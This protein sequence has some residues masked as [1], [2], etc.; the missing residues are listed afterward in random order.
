MVVFHIKHGSQEGFLYEASVQDANEVLIAGLVS[1]LKIP[2]FVSRLSVLGSLQ[3]SI[4]K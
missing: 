4:E 3:C 1:H 2:L